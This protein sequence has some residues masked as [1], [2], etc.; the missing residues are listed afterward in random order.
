[1]IHKSSTKDYIVL[2]LLCGGSYGL[3]MAIF[4]GDVEMGMFGGILFGTLFP[5]FIYIF[6]SRLEKRAVGLRQEI[7]KVRTIVCEGPSNHKKGA[8]A[9]GG[10]L[11]LTTDALE[12]YAHKVNFGG[13][14]IAILLDDI[15]AVEVKKNQLIITT[16]LETITFIVNKA[17]EW[18]K[19]ILNIL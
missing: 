17:E 19:S 3:L 16:K 13:G 14:N 8:N 2:G 11:F 5:L 9:I 6:S 18:K 10:W 15:T 4:M 1:M 12:F 7:S